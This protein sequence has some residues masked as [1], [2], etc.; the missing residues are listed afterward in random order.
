MKYLYIFGLSIASL[1]FNALA[2][3]TVIP[4]VDWNKIIEQQKEI[5]SF[6][7]RKETNEHEEKD[8]DEILKLIN[9]ME[10]WVIDK[11]N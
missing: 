2:V 4:V 6:C 9:L 3:I 5:H 1:S 11:R 10:E 8:C 7:L